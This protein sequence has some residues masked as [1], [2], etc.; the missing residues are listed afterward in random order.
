MDAN[1]KNRL[2]KLKG[3]FEALGLNYIE[4]KDR[5]T[6]DYVVKTLNEFD[7]GA[8]VSIGVVSVIDA[9]KGGLENIKVL[10]ETN[11]AL[12]SKIIRNVPFHQCYSDPRE[13]SCLIVYETLPGSKKIDRNNVALSNFRTPI[14]IDI[15]GSFY[16]GH[17][18]VHSLK[19]T[20]YDEYMDTHIF[21]DTIPIFYEMLMGDKYPMF[22]NSIYRY[23]LETLKVEG[24]NYE[25]AIKNMK[26][27]DRYKDS[28][29]VKA[30][31]A[32]QHLNSYYYATL[33]FNEYKSNPEMVLELVN[34]V[35][36]H[37]LTTRQ[38][39]DQLGLLHKDNNVTFDT[40]LDIVKTYVK[41]V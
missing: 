12:V 8:Y 20:N 33:L 39:L 24:A 34:K 37:E 14:N 40:E 28:Y 9:V 17:E 18:F 41:K 16:L 5:K 6:I 7:T 13:Y 32:G 19:D 4:A 11:A 26:K 30:T 2:I 25:R 23:R 35:L 3:E 27:G 1:E 38:L 15:L 31:M 22:R 10:G 21:G 36:H 29:K